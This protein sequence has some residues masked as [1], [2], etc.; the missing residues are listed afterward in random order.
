MRSQENEKSYEKK[1]NISNDP[2]AVKLPESLQLCQ[3]RDNFWICGLCSQSTWLK[4]IANFLRVLKD[5]IGI[6]TE[7]LELLET[8][9]KFSKEFLI[10][11]ASDCPMK[12]Q[13]KGFVTF[14]T[15]VM[16]YYNNKLE[17]VALGDTDF[18][19]Y[20]IRPKPKLRRSKRK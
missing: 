9:Q 1:A 17:V 18:D 16:S 20:E 12:P 7:T 13:D 5:V 11:V 6:K 10:W 8:L 19:T 14:Q 15:Q 2:I 3:D 4:V